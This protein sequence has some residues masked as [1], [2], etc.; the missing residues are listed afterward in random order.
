MNDERKGKEFIG[1]IT[2]GIEKNDTL[3]LK[4]IEFV[5]RRLPEWRDDPDRSSE[6]SE[7]KLNLQLCK[8][9]D[10]RA[11]NDFPMVCFN[12]E[13]PQSGKR[14]V[15]LSASPA[16]RI[17]IK[18]KLHTI[19]DPFLVLEGKRLPPPSKDREKEY[20]TGDY[21]DKIKTSGGIQRFKMGVHGA[22]LDRAAMIGYVQERSV[23]DWYHDINKWIAKLAGNSPTTDGCIWTI[24]EILE[25][26]VASES[27]GD[28]FYRSV[29]SRVDC[30]SNIKIYHIWIE[31]NT[32]KT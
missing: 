19:Y 18:A 21:G 29:H 8:F 24:G 32:E 16:S 13:E 9:L 22:A 31:M 26:L 7:V 3:D 15:D 20:V 23:N 28:A 10:S 2:F 12:H 4:T 17:L 11:R 1:R 6:E 27:K 14:S 5:R 30:K 25:P